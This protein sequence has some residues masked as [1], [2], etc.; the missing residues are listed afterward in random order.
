MT[1]TD[2]GFGKLSSHREEEDMRK[3]LG[4]GDTIATDLYFGRSW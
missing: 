4:G 1:G 3:G 2:W